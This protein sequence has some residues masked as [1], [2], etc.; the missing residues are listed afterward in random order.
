MKSYLSFLLA[1]SLTMFGVKLNAQYAESADLTVLSWNIYMLP[2]ITNLSK[3]ITK[4]DK[5]A[6]AME[7]AAYLN[8]SE[9]DIVVFQEA[10]FNPARRKLS[11]SVKENYPFQYG[12][13][14]PSKWS[15]KTS[16]GIF[17]VSKFPLQVLGTVQYEACNGAD[18]FA[19]KGA[20]L[21]EGEVNSQKFQILGTHLNAGGPHWI[22]Q[23]QYKQVRGLL[24]DFT[25]LGVPQIV[26]GDM[27]THKENEA[28]YQNMLDMLDVLDQETNS[29]QQ[30]TT[31]K[32]R[33]VIDYI[34]I[35]QNDS[36]MELEKK[37]V[38]WINPNQY[39]VIDKLNGNLSD[40]LALKARFVWP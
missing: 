19:K 3:Q 24:N 22:R 16:S 6:R 12:P 26:C 28:H 13:A 40:H 31:A 17:V 25:K 36:R 5:K 14:N 33:T 27:N 15:L 18:C 20:L 4:S 30:Y 38:L 37:E 8:S 11:K 35:R 21:L 34:F 32:D 39:E 23:E 2:G 7:I 1:F 10:F 29:G 9:V